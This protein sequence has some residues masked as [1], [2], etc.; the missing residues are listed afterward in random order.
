[1]SKIASSPKITICNDEYML[2]I[3]FKN[4][5]KTKKLDK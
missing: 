5:K 2:E 4:E 3:L 1:M